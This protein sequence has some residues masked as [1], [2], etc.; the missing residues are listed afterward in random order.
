MASGLNHSTCSPTI[1]TQTAIR[2]INLALKSIFGSGSRGEVDA[3][4]IVDTSRSSWL[5]VRNRFIPIDSAFARTLSSS[6][7][8]WSSLVDCCHWNGIT[9]NQEGRVIHLLLPSKGLKGGM[10]VSS[11][12]NLTH[13]THL[14][15]SHNSLHGTLETKFFPSL[16]CLEIFDLS[17]NLFSGKFPFSIPPKSIQTIDLSCNYFHGAIPSSFFQQ[18]W[19]LTSFNVSN[20]TFSGPIP[21]S[22]C[23]RSITNLT[24]LTILDL[25]YNHLSGVIPLNF[26]KLS[27]LKFMNLGFNSLQGN[28]P[29]SLMNCTNLVE[30]HLGF[31]YLEGDVT[32]PNFSKLSHLSKLDLGGNNFTGILPISLYSCRS[33]K[34][35]RLSVNPYLK[36]QVH[37]E[38]L[39]LK[40]LSFLSLGSVQLTNITGAIK[41]LMRCKSLHALFLASSFSGEAMPTD[42]DMVDFHGFQNLRVLSLGGCGI[43]GQIPGWLSNLKN[44]EMLYLGFNQISGSIPSWLGT[45]PKLFFVSLSSNQIS[46]E[47]PKQL[48]SL[49]MLMMDESRLDDYEFELPLISL[50]IKNPRF[51]PRRLSNFPGTIDLGLNN[52]SG[53]IPTEIG[54]LLFLRE[55]YLNSNNFLGDIPDQISDLK[56]LEVLNLSTNHLSGKIPWSMASLNFLREFNV[57]YNNI[58]GQIPKGTQLQSFNASA[59]EGNPKLCGAPLP[60]ECKEIEADNKNDNQ[61][62][63]N[64]SDELPWFYF[65]AT[66]GFIVGFWGVCGTLVLKKTWRHTYFQFL[67]NVQDLL[68][69]KT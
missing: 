63:N 36:G 6:P 42:D 8:N 43:V 38:I 21:S 2:P 10:F 55:L 4:S 62:A 40:S 7:L 14:N 61:D 39:S 66:L 33:L 5:S 59:F 41:I 11:L 15:L 64:E 49:P 20:N 16:N 60:N 28:L 17:Y 53:S 13:L 23:L 26:G 3:G 34:A 44:L 47:F 37:P 31:N 12:E 50:P 65:F 57:S 22:I 48:C 25:F 32:K 30:L 19:N 18:A 69:V 46:G 54:Q 67:D 56:Y 58:E 1:L 27:K 35:I 24:H 9:C 52:I 45:L 29:P 68:Y 51:W